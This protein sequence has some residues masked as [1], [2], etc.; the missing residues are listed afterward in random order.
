[1]SFSNP[2]GSG[3]QNIYGL[4]AAGF[5]TGSVENITV[6]GGSGDDTF[7]VNQFTSGAALAVQG[8]P[9]NDTL[10]FGSNTLAN[11]T[12]MA[13]FNFDGQTGTGDT[14]N[15]NN[16]THNVGGWTYLRELGSITASA[17]GVGFFMTDSNTEIMRINDTP[18]YGV[19]NVNAVAPGCA[20]HRKRKRRSG[21]PASG[22]G[23]QQ[24]AGDS[25]HGCLQW[26]CRWRVHY[27]L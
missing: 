12:N 1:M 3:T 16:Q 23:G 14:F 21:L 10:N 22:L 11:I 5:G 25:R 8:G 26:P 24:R 17:P 18:T 13:S 9:G 6:T 27:R 20:I 2:F 19:F 4:G 15:L 7:S